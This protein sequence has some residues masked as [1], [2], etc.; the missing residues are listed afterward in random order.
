[1]QTR[2]LPAGGIRETILADATSDAI[3]AAHGASLPFV[4]IQ[5]QPVSGGTEL[6][7]FTLSTLADIKD[8]SAKW[9]AISVDQPVSANAVEVVVGRVTGLRMSTVSQNGYWAVIH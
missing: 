2:E 9:D 1:M 7:E 4:T 8:D 5:M 6:V 3:V